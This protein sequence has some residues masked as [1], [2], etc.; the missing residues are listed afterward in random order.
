MCEKLIMFFFFCLTE[1]VDAFQFNDGPVNGSKKLSDATKNPEDSAVLTGN[2]SDKPISNVNAR[3]FPLFTPPPPTG[4]KKETPLLILFC[5][6]ILEL[7]FHY[8]HLFTYPF[9]EVLFFLFL[10]T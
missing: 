10:Y 6:L 4:F 2:M 1:Y 8:Y 3:S 5:L 9:H 7:P